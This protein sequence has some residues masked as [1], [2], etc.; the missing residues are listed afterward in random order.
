MAL[1]RCYLGCRKGCRIFHFINEHRLRIVYLSLPRP[2][3][4]YPL[5]LQHQPG[6]ARATY[7]ISLIFSEL[8]SL[9]TLALLHELVTTFCCTYSYNALS[10]KF[11]N[12]TKKGSNLYKKV[13]CET[14]HEFLLV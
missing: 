1:C 8:N 3:Q 14:L 10:Y 4:L 7:L 13:C 5:L 12:F 6:L 2:N 9:V 11:N